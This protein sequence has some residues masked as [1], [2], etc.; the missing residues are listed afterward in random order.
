MGTRSNAVLATV[1][2][3]AALVVGP[4]A[5]AEAVVRPSAR[6]GTV[7]TLDSGLGA[8]KYGISPRKVKRLLGKPNREVRVRL[9]ESK[10]KRL[11][12][13]EYDK[14]Y[15]MDVN[16]GTTGRVR[17]EF[18]SLSHRQFRTAEGIRKG[19]A[20]DA[21]LAAYP[22]ATCGRISGSTDTMCWVIVG[23]ASTSFLF[24]SRMRVR[25]IDWSGES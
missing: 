23:T 9:G 22:S 10:R 11:I 25:R 2:T 24:D 7:L 6:V 8:L 1:A 3:T 4:V 20:M 17:L 18:V 14:K 16:F 19:S 13:F 5:P 12:R 21:V 15:G